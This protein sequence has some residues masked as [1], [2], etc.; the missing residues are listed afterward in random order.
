MPQDNIIEVDKIIAKCPKCDKIIEETIDRAKD[1]KHP[2]NYNIA[3]V[4]FNIALEVLCYYVKCPH[5]KTS[6]TIEFAKEPSSKPVEMT[7]K[8]YY[9]EPD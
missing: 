6:Y 2:M 5:C 9:N 8:L 1:P 4:P 3:N 7:L